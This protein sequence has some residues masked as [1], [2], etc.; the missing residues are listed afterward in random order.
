MP[1]IKPVP[2]ESEMTYSQKNYYLMGG[3]DKRRKSD[4]V[5]QGL[6]DDPDDVLGQSQI[7]FR[8]RLKKINYQ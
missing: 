4:W 7:L 8:S 2:E 3:K 6:I 1:Y 5:A